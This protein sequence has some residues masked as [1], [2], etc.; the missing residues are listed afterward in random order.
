MSPQRGYPNVVTEG[1]QWIVLG[2]WPDRRRRPALTLPDLVNALTLID[3]VNS[4]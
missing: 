3:V 4:R 1:V 2:D